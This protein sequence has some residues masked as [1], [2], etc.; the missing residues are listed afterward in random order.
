MGWKL[1]QGSV[2]RDGGAGWAEGGGGD[3][4][5]YRV[6]AVIAGAV[7]R[8]SIRYRKAARGAMPPKT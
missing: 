3:K 5:I 8:L 4:Q 2:L 6:V 1:P 7:H